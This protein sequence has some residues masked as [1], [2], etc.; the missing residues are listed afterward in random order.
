MTQNNLTTADRAVIRRHVKARPGVVRVR[1]CW[2]GDV[3]AY[4]I[5]PNS[6]RVG[7]WFAGY[8][9]DVLRE[10]TVQI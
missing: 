2:D 1:I 7:W 3:E 6:N 9:I 4:G 10:A 8:D 5:I